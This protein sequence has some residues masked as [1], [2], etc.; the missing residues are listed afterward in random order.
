MVVSC[1]R[2]SSRPAFKRHCQPQTSCEKWSGASSRGGGSYVHRGKWTSRMFG[3][4]H[5]GFSRGRQTTHGSLM[6]FT[7]LNATIQLVHF[8]FCFWW[9]RPIKLLRNNIEN[10]VIFFYNIR[11]YSL[12]LLCMVVCLEILYKRSASPLR[13]SSPP[14]PPSA[15]K[16]HSWSY[17]NHIWFILQSIFIYMARPQ[18]VLHN[19]NFVI[20]RDIDLLESITILFYP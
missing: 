17:Y 18:R 7:S 11:F 13:H 5:R 19:M 6:P 15:K 3:D 12:A 4:V 20:A 2:P 14:S 10:N 9:R 1:G 16:T 8:L